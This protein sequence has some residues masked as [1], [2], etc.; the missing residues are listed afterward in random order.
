MRLRTIL[1]I[2]SCI[3]FLSASAAGYLYYFSSKRLA[4]READRDAARTADNIRDHIGSHLS[5]HLKSAK[6]LAGLQEMTQALVR[7]EGA[8]LAQANGTLDHFQRAL[9]VDV[10]YLMDREGNTIAASNRDAPDSFVGQNYAF[11][12]YF[13]EAIQGRPTVHMARG[14]TSHKRGVYYSHPVHGEAPARPVGVLVIKASM[15]P[16]EKELVGV[17]EGAVSLVN[18]AGLVF[19]SNRSNWLF[20]FLWKPP[21]AEADEVAHSRQFG[22]GPFPWLGFQQKD[23]ERVTD[24]DGKEYVC[25]VARVDNY[26]GWAV[27]H[28]QST[29]A[30]SQ[31]VPIRFLR[32]L[33]L[34]TLLLCAFIGLLVFLLY[35]K[36]SYHIAQR[37]AAEAALRQSEGTLRQAKEELTRYSRELE[38]R[39][40]ARTQEVT[41]ILK[42][43]PNVVYIKDRDLRYSLVNDRFEQ[44]FRITREQIRGKRDSE[45]LSG[46]MCGLLEDGDLEVLETEVYV[47][48]EQRLAG[49]GGLQSYLCIKFPLYDGNGKVQGLCGIV[50]D[51][52]A[53]K[54]AEDRLRRL[55][56]KIMTSQEKERTTIARELHDEL[57][58]ML[59]ALRFDAVWITER[60]PEKD[61]TAAERA[62]G[63]CELIDKTIDEVRGMAIRLRPGV[64]DDLGLLAGLEWYTSDFEKRT[65]IQCSF[66][67]AGVERLSDLLSTTAYRI[68]QEALTNV[69]RH[70][71]ASHALVALEG[72]DGHLTLS[73]RDDGKGLDAGALPDRDCLGM[74]SMR[75]RAS[76]VGGSL[77]VHPYPGGG[78]EVVFRVSLSREKEVFS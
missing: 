9:S 1:L 37:M 52:T 11:R 72:W 59:T 22:E 61:P 15:G 17:Q 7:H 74:A 63:M 10:C 27:I 60:L 55:S 21:H 41:G 50:T 19:A 32:A 35:R 18:P 16:I 29:E 33:G 76:L 51:I 70:S 14:I 57:G 20:H 49:D 58:Q 67:H 65:G 2:L 34:V 8:S 4:L 38:A 53:L 39:V 62:R 48:R 42:Y 46:E 13:R 56:A 24:A 3:T 25:H 77:D 28:L 68:A 75:E 54:A 23:A 36:A 31:K 26:P 73:V 6:V 5:E 40:Q 71:G 45:V 69:A 78:T 66:Q 12:P 30:L 44:M 47:Q 43:T 64:L